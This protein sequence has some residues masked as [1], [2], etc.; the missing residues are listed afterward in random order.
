M[1]GI[2]LK[3]RLVGTVTI[4]VLLSLWEI[5]AH[6]HWVDARI[7]PPPSEFLTTIYSMANEQQ[8]L[9]NT[10]LTVRRF[11]IGTLLGTSAGV[12][13]G[14]TMGLFRSVRAVLYP[15][16]ALFYPVPRIALFPLVLILVGLN[17][18]SNLI[19]I[20][21]GPFFTMLISAM[22]AVMNVDPIYRDVAHNFNA[23]TKDLYLR[24]TLPSIAPALMDGL[25]ISVGLGLLGTVAVEFLVGDSGL[26]HVIWNSWQMLSLQQSM[27]GIV[28]SAIVGFIFYSSVDLFA[29][30]L[31]PWYEPTVFR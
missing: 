29:K 15:L 28:V 7:L 4:I 1:Q 24:V 17:E 22:G 25:R 11:L 23:G 18:T 26:G 12:F 30:W 2:V 21:L 10:A 27:A 13:L 9:G 19:M 31:L 14:L 16:F 5:S 3:D 8:L 20:S 6:L